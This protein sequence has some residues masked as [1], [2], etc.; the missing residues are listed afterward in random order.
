M[1]NIYYIRLDILLVL[2]FIY[3]KIL[4]LLEYHEKI[5]SQGLSY[6]VFLFKAS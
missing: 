3:L 2:S 4:M 6:L 5:L 1:L